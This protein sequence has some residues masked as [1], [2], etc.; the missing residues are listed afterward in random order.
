MNNTPGVTRATKDSNQAVVLTLRK[1]YS[2]LRRGARPATTDGRDFSAATS[3]QSINGRTGTGNPGDVS[4][5]IVTGNPWEDAE[6][7]LTAQRARTTPAPLNHR[8]SFDDASGVIMLPDGGEWIEEEEDSDEEDYGAT[9]HGLDQSQTDTIVSDAPLSSSPIASSSSVA[10]GTP[11]VPAPSRSRY[12]TYFHH[13]ERR[14]Q[15]IPGAF[16]R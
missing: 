5:P 7:G 12:G 1:R 4:D 6:P 9:E 13:P 2:S 11:V 10:S 16:P 3:S 15:P 8:L 14:R